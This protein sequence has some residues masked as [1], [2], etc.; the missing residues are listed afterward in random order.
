[1]AVRNSPAGY[2][3]DAEKSFC[4]VTTRR[5]AE[6]FRPAETRRPV[7]LGSTSAA[8]SFRLG[9]LLTPFGLR[10]P[11]SLPLRCLPATH[12]PQA[13]RGPDSTAG[14]TAVLDRAV[15]SPWQGKI[16]IPAAPLWSN[17]PRRRY[18]VHDP[19]E[20]M[21]P[22]GSP[23]RMLVHPPRALIHWYL[24]PSSIAVWRPP[25]L[26]PCPSAKSEGHPGRWI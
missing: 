9:V 13:M 19:W 22:W 18:A 11:L 4:C 16:A 1:M 20:V 24:V 23:G 6:P 7:G 14:S 8:V 21:L 10:P 15:H 17:H 25:S 2:T 12:G 5:R 3:T 26:T